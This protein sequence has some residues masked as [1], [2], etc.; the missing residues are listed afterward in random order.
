MRN[1]LRV[2]VAFAS[3]CLMATAAS[4]ATGQE[5]INRTTGV[6]ECFWTSQGWVCVP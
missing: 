6:Q 2:A 4:V 1:V 3:L 5:E